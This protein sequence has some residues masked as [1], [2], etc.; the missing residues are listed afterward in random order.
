MILSSVFDAKVKKSDKR[1]KKLPLAVIR[2]VP[3]LNKTPMAQYIYGDNVAIVV[4]SHD[5]IAIL[6]RQKDIAEGFRNNFE[7]LWK[8]GK[9]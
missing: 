4:W 2:Y 3:D 8:V 5:P 1:I 9:A 6:I 7:V